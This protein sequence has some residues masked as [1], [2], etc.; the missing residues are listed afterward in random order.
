M[1]DIGEF[2]RVSCLSFHA[3]GAYT[4]EQRD[5]GRGIRNYEALK[6]IYRPYFGH[7]STPDIS[8]L[9][10]DY[11]LTE[12]T[13]G[14]TGGLHHFAK[15][16]EFGSVVQIPE[17]MLRHLAIHIKSAVSKGKGQKEKKEQTTARHRE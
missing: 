10:L 4:V 12:V 5:S 16:V 15:I 3:S 7:N 14:F 8:H 9:P 13:P 17:D 11:R 2:V 6:L 1:V